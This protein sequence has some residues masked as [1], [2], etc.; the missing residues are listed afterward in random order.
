MNKRLRKSKND[1]IVSGVCGGLGNYFNIDSNV[2]RFLWFISFLFKSKI[3]FLIYLIFSILIPEENYSYD[4]YISNTGNLSQKNN[5][6]LIGIA[7]ILIGFFMLINKV[8]PK[9]LVFFKKVFS[10]WPLLLIGFGFYLL[11]E[12]KK[13]DR[14]Y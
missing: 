2:L 4:A 13:K 12:E 6:F 3:A 14:R 8:W 1:R 7:L 5:K 10:F 9:I 11:L